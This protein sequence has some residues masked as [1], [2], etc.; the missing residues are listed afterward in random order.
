MVN[1]V[2]SET[3]SCNYCMK[4]YWTEEIAEKCEKSHDTGS[5]K[6]ET[7]GGKDGKFE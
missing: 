4:L 6:E 3:Y 2:R 7:Q 5:T 1:K